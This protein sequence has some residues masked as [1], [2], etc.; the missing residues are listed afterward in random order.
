MDINNIYNIDCIKGMNKMIK[1]SIK[2]DLI[3]A[4]PPY[5]ISKTSNFH[6]MKDRKKSRTGTDFGSWDKKF[7]NKP[8][9][10]RSYDILKN[11]GSLL[12]FNDF[13]KSSEIIKIAT[14]LG[15]I[16]KDSLIWKKTNPMPRNRDRR[17][18]PDVE[19]IMWFVKP[20]KWTFNRGNSK[21][22]SSVISF[23]SESGGG[24]KRYHP[25]QK[26]IK[27]IEHLI[28]IHSNE[29]DVVLDP[30]SGSGSTAVSATRLKRKF[31][32]FEIDEKYYK[33][34]MERLNEKR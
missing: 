14:D 6:M 29:G 10:R 30:F 28:K 31:I 7:S 27:L 13:K 34:S 1:K 26:P 11:G 8:W 33:K 16:Y 4:D 2:V 22:Q 3:I 20:G 5:V 25:T 9:L 21:Y 15:F 17:Y 24:F 18:V 23:P 12:V 32:G 19:L